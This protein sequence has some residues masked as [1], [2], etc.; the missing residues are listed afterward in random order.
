MENFVVVTGAT[1]GI[2]LVTA[3]EL[4]RAGAQVVLVSRS[5]EK[6]ARIAEQIAQETGKAAPRY[7]AADLSEQVHVR[8]AADEIASMLPRIDVLV[9]NAGGIFEDRRLTADGIEMTWALNHLSYFLLTNRLLPLLLAAP[10]ARVVNVSS[11]AHWMAR[12]GI[13]FDDLQFAGKYSGW[14]AY[15]HS[16]LANIL[17]SN[18]FAQ[19]TG[20]LS[21]ALH[22][23]AVNTEFGRGNKGP[24]WKLLYALW[25]LFTISPEKGAQTSIYL[26]SS[27]QAAGV[28]G[29]YF[30]DSRPA[31]A[32]AAAT[33]PAAA[34]RLWDLSAAQVGL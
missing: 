16:K 5:A 22:P 11:N 10:A 7:V 24:V 30:S 33:D 23:G 28:S 8:R 3:R 9:N 31:R 18:E 4:T 2:G 25:P 26:A 27:Q 1:A 13:R 19:R 20:L 12:D 21:N 17:F 32:S 6:C 15:G 29:R 34:K 14:Q